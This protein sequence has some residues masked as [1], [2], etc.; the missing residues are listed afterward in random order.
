MAVRVSDE[1]A[2]GSAVLFCP[3]CREPFEGLSQCPTHDLELVPFRQ[4]PADQEEQDDAALPVASPRM[5]R[6]LLVVGAALTL[7]AFFLPL[8]SLSGQLS[9]SSSLY[10]LART[11]ERLLWLVPMSGFAQLV[12]LRRRRTPRELRG[13]RVFVLMCALL[14]SVSVL[15]SVLGVRAAAAL[16]TARMQTAVDMHVGA[17]SWLTWLAALPMLLAGAHLGVHP[18]RHVKL[19]SHLS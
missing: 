10:A 11:R 13:S 17:G 12:V 2:S 14:P 8:A 1:H 3:F 5:G 15:Y 19:G 4:L 18:P 7:L 16:L 9:A 6:G